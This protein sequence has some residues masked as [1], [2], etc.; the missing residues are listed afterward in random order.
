MVGEAAGLQNSCSLGTSALTLFG[1]RI[2]TDVI[3]N[4]IILDLRWTLNPMTGTFV[5]SR[6]KRTQTGTPREESHAEKMEPECSHAA[7][8]RGS[9]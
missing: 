6:E 1:R 4:E 5:R 2:F 3:R 8:S 9:I 7:T